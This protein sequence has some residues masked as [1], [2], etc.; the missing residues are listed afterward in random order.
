MISNHDMHHHMHST[1]HE[2]TKMDGVTDAF[3]QDTT[4]L[5][6]A[7]AP[8]TIELQ[9]DQVFELQAERVRKGHTGM[10]NPEGAGG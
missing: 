6:E 5:A 10:L 3:S 2:E 8:Q 1:D 4:G 7:I 9:P